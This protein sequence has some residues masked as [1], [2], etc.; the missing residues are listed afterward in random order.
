MLGLIPDTDS[1]HA[2]LSKQDVRDLSIYLNIDDYK[3]GYL[4]LESEF[5]EAKYL[6]QKCYMERL[7]DGS[8][9]V[10]IAGL[11]KRLAPI[12]TFENFNIGF[13]T[14]DLPK[15]YLDKI[16]YKMTYKQVKGGVLLVKTDFTIK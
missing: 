10:T 6:R 5:T 4:K 16:G 8:L 7:P 14:K 11:P 15:E 1:I 9:N 2:F 3:L 12:M 13:S